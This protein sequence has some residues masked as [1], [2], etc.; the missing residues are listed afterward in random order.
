[1]SNIRIRNKSYVFVCVKKKLY[2]YVTHSNVNEVRLRTS[3][4]IFNM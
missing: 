3:I 2:A 4:C 1:M